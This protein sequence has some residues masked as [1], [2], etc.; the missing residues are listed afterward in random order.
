M[1]GSPILFLGGGTTGLAS[2]CDVYVHAHLTQIYRQ[3]EEEADD[4][5]ADTHRAIRV[6]RRVASGNKKVLRQLAKDACAL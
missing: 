5:R 1:A 3:L 2:V 6:A 4:V